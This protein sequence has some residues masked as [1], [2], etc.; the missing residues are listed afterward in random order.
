MK[1]KGRMEGRGRVM[2]GGREEGGTRRQGRKGGGRAGCR[3]EERKK[4]IKGKGRGK[5]GKEEGT[6]KRC[7]REGAAWDLY[8]VPLD[9]GARLP[10]AP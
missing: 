10:V 3:E 2:E 9:P 7:M 6:C 5:G 8:S 1:R 4:W